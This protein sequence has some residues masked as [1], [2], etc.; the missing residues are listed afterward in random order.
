[1]SASTLLEQTLK[2]ASRTDCRTPTWISA[3]RSGSVLLVGSDPQG[4][5]KGALEASGSSVS[6][7]CRF[8]C[9]ESC[10]A[11]PARTWPE[12]PPSRPGVKVESSASSP[13]CYDA[14]VMRVPPSTEAFVFAVDAAASV[15]QQGGTLVLFGLSDEGA[16]ESTLRGAI[17][18]VF[19][20][21]SA[22]ASS[23]EGAA[24]AFVCRRTS[25]P[26]LRGAVDAWR[27]EILFTFRTFPCAAT[28]PTML[29]TDLLNLKDSLHRTPVP[30]VQQI[31]FSVFPGFFA[32]GALDVMTEA[33]LSCLPMPPAR[34]R[35]LD[36]G[37]G[38]GALAATLAWLDPSLRLTLLDADA[39]AIAA[40]E[41]NMRH[42]QQ[43]ASGGESIEGQRHAAARV[44]LS[45]G[46]SAVPSSRRFDLIVSN[47]PVHVGAQDDFRVLECLLAGAPGHLKRGGSLWVVAQAQVPVGRLAMAVGSWRRVRPISLASGRFVAWHAQITEA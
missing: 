31:P 8:E 18:P 37:C 46:F 47:P 20:E 6:H 25:D 33:L 32:G 24:A 28:C 30:R 16:K 10:P 29:E 42:V 5:I 40:A 21:W 43:T 34:S 1:M 36:F 11:V 12:P 3:I 41:A 44:L 26:P 19:G 14:V 9:D 13:R 39:L 4:L 38:S 7:W 15:L 17:G 23:P 35:V 45:D 22:L 2:E 27:T